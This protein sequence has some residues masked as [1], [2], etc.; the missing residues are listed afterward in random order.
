[1]KVL[2]TTI[3]LAIMLLLTPM[4]SNA[5]DMYYVHE[6]V[7]KPSKVMEYEGVLQELLTLVNK[8]KLEDTRWITLVSNNSHYS[9]ISPLAN[10]A[11]LDKP[12]FVAQ[13]AEKAGKEVVSDIFNRMNTCY[14]TELDYILTLDKDL[15]Y[16]PN[17]IT[18]TPE[19]ENYRNN[20]LF[21]ISPSN[22]S[23]VK[24]K[25][26]AVKTLFESKGSKMYYRVYKSGFGTAGE[27]YMVAVAAKDAEDMEKKSKANEALMGKELQE[28]LNQLY[29]NSL[30]Y[31]KLEGDIRP[32]L[33]YSP[34]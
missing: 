10:M 2:K 29:F 32:D 28:T 16:M 6:D 25:M 7:V 27:Y 21:Y 30:R 34:K 24:E 19:G 15:T 33:S 31:E 11:E 17:G 22:R 1:M 8:H 13:L 5:Q 18:Q 20:H 9:Y 14:D 3:M 4:I 26:K 12:S 23:V